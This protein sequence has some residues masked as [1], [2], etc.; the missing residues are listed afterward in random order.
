MKS[1]ITIILLLISL[2]FFAP[3]IKA[4]ES[5]PSATPTNSP[6]ICLGISANPG[7]GT[8]PLSVKFS[9]AGYDSN[10]DIT[11]A[12]FGF[13]VDQK[14]LVEK[15]IG[16][17]GS[18]TTTYTYQTP[19]SYNVTCRIRDNNGAFSNYPSYCT[20]TIVVSDNVLTPTPIRT[21]IPTQPA[22]TSEPTPTLEPSPTIEIMPT[23]TI[24]SPTPEPTW[25]SSDK[26]KQLITMLVISGI[27]IA[28]ALSLH[29]FFD[30]R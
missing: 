26:I 23:I 4:Q 14:Q 29:A 19:G 13:G 2:G 28:V 3:S 8:K 21:P 20:Y 25:W 1:F 5:T 30:K 18:L 9:C 10:N 16:Q 17:Y 12:E 22:P 11:A 27:T 24:P 15:N 7:A 6:P